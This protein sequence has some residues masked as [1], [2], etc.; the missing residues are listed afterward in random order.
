MLR[1]CYFQLMYRMFG[2]VSIHQHKTTYPDNESLAETSVMAIGE[3][4]KAIPVLLHGISGIGQ[5]EA[6]S[7][8]VYGTTGVLKLRHWS[9]LSLAQ[10]DSP[11]E[12]FTSFASVKSL[13]E[14][15]F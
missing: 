10:K 3:T 15:F 2:G 6:L 4:K 7:F 11:F 9:E 14:K 8:I 12:F 1:V 13:I 5:A